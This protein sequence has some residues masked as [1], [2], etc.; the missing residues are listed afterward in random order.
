MSELLRTRVSLQRMHCEATYVSAFSS[1][2]G[3][4]EYYNIE[5]TIQLI[6]ALS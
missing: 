4:L 2:P 6:T 1:D 5:W 3:M